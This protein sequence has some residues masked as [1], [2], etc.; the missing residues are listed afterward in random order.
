MPKKIMISAGESSGEMYGAMLSRE[1]KKRWPDAEIFGMGG[2]HME[3]EGVKLIAPISHI[4]GIFEAVSHLVEIKKTFN[5]VR[6]ALTEQKPDIL[7]LIDFPDFNITLARHA[8]AAG[9]PILYYVSPQVWAWRT[10]RIKKIAAL[11]DRMAVLFPFE[12]DIYKD[13]GLPCEFVGHPMTEIIHITE[14][15][16]ELKERLGLDPHKAVI[17]MLP[18]S[19][20]GEIERHKLL[21]KETA[22]KVHARFPD[23]QIAVPL[24]HGT[25]ITEDLPDYI[26]IIYGKTTETIACSEAA[27]VASGT[28]TFQTALLG[29]P[30]VVF[31]KLSFLTF[32]LA[33]FLAK[34]RHVSLV[35]LLTDKDVVKELLQNA[36]TPERMFIELERI[37]T[38]QSYRNDMLSD[39]NAI[40]ELMHGKTPSARVAAIVGSMAGLN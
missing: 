31:Y 12:V 15:K 26:K 39:L 40:K 19:R 11:V 33:K 27:A 22:E 16:E 35:N 13:S 29:I 1:I 4:I 37:M 3:A 9:I 18:G 6:D 24:M 30:M 20:P 36:A 17:A 32:Y 8:K 2:Q 10:G 23:I 28:A 25:T 38:D 21:I 14:T 5:R 34:V 7:I